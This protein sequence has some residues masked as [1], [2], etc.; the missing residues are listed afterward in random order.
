MPDIFEL[1]SKTNVLASSADGDAITPHDTNDLPN[2]TREIRVGGGG[3]L[4]IMYPGPA[5][6]VVTIPSLPA[7]AVIAIRARRILATGTTATA[8]FV[9]Y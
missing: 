2:V 8:I 9:Q 7:G 5:Q 6:K 1:E 4:R 3:D